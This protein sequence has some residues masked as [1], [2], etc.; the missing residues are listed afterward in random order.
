M[1]KVSRTVIQFCCEAVCARASAII[2]L[3]TVFCAL[4]ICFHILMVELKP[5]VN[6]KTGLNE[7]IEFGGASR[8][9]AD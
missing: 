4:L 1:S 6:N 5:C 7:V 3:F 2:S 9:L 8:L